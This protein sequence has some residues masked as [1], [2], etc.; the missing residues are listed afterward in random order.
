MRR[1]QAE[2]YS[3]G[4]YQPIFLRAGILGDFTVLP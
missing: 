2:G 3:A 1:P 4:A